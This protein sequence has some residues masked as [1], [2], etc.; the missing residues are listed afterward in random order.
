[1][2]TKALL[3]A[4]LA[5]GVLFTSCEKD[6][7][8]VIPSSKVT[9]TDF[10]AS[11]VSQLAISDIFN[12]YV[13]F[14]ETEESVWVEANE[15]IHHL[16][17][18]HQSGD[19]LIIGLQNN[20]KISGLPVL[21]V[22]VKTASLKQVSAEGAARVEFQNQLIAN[23]LELELTGAS[24][25]KGSVMLNELVA[26]LEGAG[27]MEISGS[28]GYSEIDAEGAAEITDFGFSTNTLDAN[29]AAGSTVSVT[30]NKKLNVYASGGSSVYYKGDGTIHY[31]HLSGGSKIIRMD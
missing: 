28:S 15:N 4:I 24:S 5:I 11:G 30:V 23:Y 6:H 14:S 22:Y 10:S 19:Q 13:S 31:Q 20:S 7:F 9:T 8:D 26:D 1:M 3:A 25:F 16:I 2:K 27:K 12:V 17:E 18:L 21:N 29:L